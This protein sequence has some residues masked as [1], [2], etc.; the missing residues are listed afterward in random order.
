MAIPSYQGYLHRSRIGEAISDGL[1]DEVKSAVA[2]QVTKP[3][4]AAGRPVEFAPKTRFVKSIAVDYRAGTV[5]I[6]L[7]EMAIGHVDAIPPGSWISFTAVTKDG[8]IVEWK[9]DKKGVAS[10]LLPANCR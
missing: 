6:N 10:K 2:A 9:C 1:R 4:S 3:G 8:A 5:F 7:D